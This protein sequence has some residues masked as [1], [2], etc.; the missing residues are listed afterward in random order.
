MNTSISSVTGGRV[1]VD[2]G[3]AHVDLRL[4]DGRFAG[5]GR[6]AET[7]AGAVLDVEGALVT[8]GLIDMHIHGAR[9]HGFADAADEGVSEICRYLLAEGVTSC[10]ASLASASVGELGHSLQRLD[11]HRHAEDETAILG[12]H[13]EGPFLAPEQRGAHS[14]G[15][16]RS[17]TADDI[18]LLRRWRDLIKVITVAPEV[19]GVIAL[20]TELSLVGIAV[21]VGHTDAPGKA[22]GDIYR[23][24]ATHITHLWSGQSLLRRDGPWRVPGMLE[25]SLASTGMTAEII[26]DGRHLPVELLEV[27]RRCLRED[28]V[29][30]S[31]ATAG[32]GMPDGYRYALGE[33]QCEVRDGVGVVV[34]QDSF[35]GSVTPL[36]EMVRYLVRDCGWDVAETFRMATENP[37]RALGLQGKRGKVEAGQVADLVVWDEELRPLHVIRAGRLLP[38]V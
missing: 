6:G 30:V 1:L 27:A 25:A 22:L 32:T 10:V 13:L 12:V 24:G 35:G 17:P 33:V 26:A 29:I 7:G 38:A 8:P 31:D 11:R 4:N 34:G 20:T 9:G 23:A 5:S 15:A 37:A 21:A 19:D 16:L 14:A 18:E 2:G 28:L 36:P 3:F